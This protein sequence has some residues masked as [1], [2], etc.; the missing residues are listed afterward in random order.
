[1]RSLIA[2]ISLTIA[3]G[4]MAQMPNPN[5]IKV[6][7]SALWGYQYDT[8][9]AQIV[10]DRGALFQGGTLSSGYSTHDARYVSPCYL[11]CGT[12]TI[13]LPPGS[14]D[15]SFDVNG[16]SRGSFSY[17]YMPVFMTHDGSTTTIGPTIVQDSD[18]RLTGTWYQHVTIGTSPS[19]H[20]A[21]YGDPALY[22][23]AILLDNVTFTPPPSN[24][25]LQIRAHLTTDVLPIVERKPATSVKTVIIPLGA[26][27]RLGLERGSGPAATP[28][29]TLITIL[30][31]TPSGPMALPPLHV[32]FGSSVVTEFSPSD[33][34][35]LKTLQALHRGTAQLR[36]TPQDKP[37]DTVDVTLKVVDPEH[38]GPNP[39]DWPV[40]SDVITV[41]DKMGMIPQMLKAQMEQESRAGAVSRDG[42]DGW[43]YE[44]TRDL[45]TVQRR[46]SREPYV[47]FTA[48][49]PRGDQLDTGDLSPR[50]TLRIQATPPPTPLYRNIVSTDVDITIGQ[51]FKGSNCTRR[52]KGVCHGQ[53]WADP[54]GRTA[55]TLSS[56]NVIAQTP[57]ASSWGFL[58]IMYY[59][60]IEDVKWQGLSGAKN[61]R[62]LFDNPTTIASE[63]SSL[64]A[65]SSFN[66]A[67]WHNLYGNFGDGM[68][69]SDSHDFE[70]KLRRMYN[71]YNPA[72]HSKPGAVPYFDNYES[73]IIGRSQHFL[74]V[75]SGPVLN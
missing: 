40:D 51:I 42:G 46:L 6:T 22:W 27:L 72:W 47:H 33:Y 30:R 5:E 59:V 13:D 26:E 12:M 10:S 16:Y 11:R 25:S 75:R 44:P 15:V 29:P 54:N 41:A 57:M 20:I 7:F 69:F 48:P 18:G 1:M 2:A 60:A 9:I 49:N 37:A 71:P 50:E 19:G 52:I 66:V 63:V 34:E 35:D 67:H 53:N 24:S 31:Q 64:F 32:L 55:Q 38:L 43:R 8:E 39:T 17:T 56:S 23:Y 14:T 28:V 65:G 68:F 73:A 4:A 58:Q 21:L 61:P 36:L 62:Y 3:A 45:D 70:S 74:P